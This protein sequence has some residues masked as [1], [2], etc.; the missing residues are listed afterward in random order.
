MEVDHTQKKELFKEFKKLPM[1]L[2]QETFLSHNAIIFLG[3]QPITLAGPNGHSGS[4]YSLA[5]DDDNLVTGAY[6]KTVKV[7]NI[8]TGQFKLTFE[9]IISGVTSVIIHDTKVV[10]T[11]A[12]DRNTAKIWDIYSG[13]LLHMFK[14]HTNTI[15]SVA[16]SADKVITGSADNTAKIWDIHNGQLLHT[17]P[18]HIRPIYYIEI[19]GDKVATGSSDN[20]VRVW[21]IHT[22]QLLHTLTNHSG[23][24]ITSLAIDSDVIVAGTGNKTVKIWDLNT[25]QLLHTLE[26]H[27]G[28][29][30][31]VL[32][33]DNK[34]VTK[35]S[36]NMVKIWNI[37]D[38]T[39]LHTFY[40]QKLSSLA[41]YKDTCVTGSHDNTAT[42][43]DLANG[44]PL[45]ILEG[46][47]K[48]ILSVA[49]NADNVITG[50]ADATVKIWPLMLNL[51]G[52]S[53][54]NPLLW[55]IQK[56]D[57]LQLNFI[58]RACQAT[59]TG[60]DLIIELPTKLGKIQEDDSQEQVDGNIYFSFPDAVRQYLRARLNIRK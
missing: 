56:I 12:P 14:G 15:S 35:A 27:T 4:I 24:I 21:N 26:G 20:I 40:I 36:D 51:K 49:I 34:V 18:G 32:I 47:S 41:V 37:L 46:H 50:S 55:I 25:T 38:G 8:H 33:S 54:D 6:D 11:S 59:V 3:N 1:E 16:I 39:L 31:S 30:S 57:M 53:Q 23:G 7:W 45:K 52:T 19:N 5:I 44:R 43:W 13:K 9:D 2:Q 10:T 60:Q 29:I 17:L 48:C 28:Q 58:D 22:G 42:I